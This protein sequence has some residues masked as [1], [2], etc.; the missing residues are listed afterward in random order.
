[1]I[2]LYFIKIQKI[3]ITNLDEQY[4]SFFV[5]KPNRI[6]LEKGTIDRYNV[7]FLGK[8]DAKVYID[9][10]R[11]LIRAACILY[12]FS[13]KL[14]LF[15]DLINVIEVKTDSD[16]IETVKTLYLQG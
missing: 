12:D 7:L 4:Y 3:F 14:K 6:I 8:D 5:L 13:L 16:F 15:Y 11:N 2:H 10:S 9:K 1:M